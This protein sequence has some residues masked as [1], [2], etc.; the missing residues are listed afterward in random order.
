MTYIDE[1]VVAYALINEYWTGYIEII[2]FSYLMK[3][4]YNLEDDTWDREMDKASKRVTLAFQGLMKKATE[5]KIAQSAAETEADK[6]RA[7]ML[8][9]ANQVSGGRIVSNP[10]GERLEASMAM[11]GAEDSESPI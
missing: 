6:T 4:G 10:F 9:W 5:V 2:A 1:A 8:E 11:E 3:N 7:E